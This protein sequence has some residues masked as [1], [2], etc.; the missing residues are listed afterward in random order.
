MQSLVRSPRRRNRERRGLA[1]RAR[2]QQGLGERLAGFG[3]REVGALV[4]EQ[5]CA[6]K[7]EPPASELFRHTGD[8]NRRGLALEFAYDAPRSSGL[9]EPGR[10]R[11]TQFDGNQLQLSFG[12]SAHRRTLEAE[13]VPSKLFM[14]DWFHLD[15]QCKFAIVE[16]SMVAICLEP[17]RVSLRKRRHC[18]ELR[19]G[20]VRH[21]PCTV[22]RGSSQLLE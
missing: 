9:T 14:F 7:H 12:Y 22:R 8:E 15:K 2:A 19:A 21:N 18:F 11:G 13:Q 6:L 5:H 4:T 16:I 10:P 3:L 20:S 17:W 1:R